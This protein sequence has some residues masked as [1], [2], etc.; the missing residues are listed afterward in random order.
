[1]NQATG[2]S[3]FTGPYPVGQSPGKGGKGAGFAK[4]QQKPQAHQGYAWILLE[5]KAVLRHEANH[6]GQS[7]PGNSGKRLELYEGLSDSQTNLQEPSPGHSQT[8]TH[9]G[10]GRASDL[11]D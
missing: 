7:R 4:P 6:H 9:L 11:T 5:S 3:S 8:E 1:M 2:H 10:Y